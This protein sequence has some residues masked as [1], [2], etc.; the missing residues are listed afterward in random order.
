MG[1]IVSALYVAR[2]PS[3]DGH[4]ITF[5][6]PFFGSLA[7]YQALIHQ[8]SRYEQWFGPYDSRVYSRVVRSMPSLFELTPTYTPAAVLGNIGTELNLLS[9]SE[10]MRFGWLG[11][12]PSATA[13]RS[14]AE[15]SATRAV[16]DQV[17]SRTAP[18]RQTFRL[19]AGALPATDEVVNVNPLDGRPLRWSTSKGDGTVTEVSASA[20][21]LG[22]AY[23]SFS[24]HRTMF[25]DDFA[26]EILRRTLSGQSPSAGPRRP[27]VQVQGG[28][29]IEVASVEIEFEGPYLESG[30]PSS[31]SIRLENPSGE[32]IGGVAVEGELVSNRREP[33]ERLSFT[34]G[35]SV[36]T[37][38]ATFQAPISQGLYA[39]TMNVPAL[40]AY[41]RYFASTRVPR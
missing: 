2:N 6:T 1:G 31:V 5:G 23:P 41:E 30:A 25:E 40:G 29:Q 16:F 12:T 3:F 22:D 27:V 18:S 20:G 28:G 24:D 38:S 11:P 32:G 21:Y 19:V 13:R 15:A 37:Y 17:L 7:A 39:V 10:W 14:L 36:G 8:P 9:E 35:G 26:R 34:S 4:V 33:L